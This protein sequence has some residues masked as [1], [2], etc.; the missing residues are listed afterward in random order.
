MKEKDLIYWI[1]FFLII[2]AEYYIQPCARARARVCVCV[3]VCVRARAHL[4]NDRDRQLTWQWREPNN[5][6]KPWNVLQIPVRMAVFV[7]MDSFFK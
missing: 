6:Q 1:L 3:R 5:H 2:I 4:F 7:S